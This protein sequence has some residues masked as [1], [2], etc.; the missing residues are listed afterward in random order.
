MP[1]N[2]LEVLSIKNRW[3][4]INAGLYKASNPGK[5][6][7]GFVYEW[8]IELLSSNPGTIPVAVFLLEKIKN[9][10]LAVSH[11]IIE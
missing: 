2:V 4:R 5:S 7:S 10:T 6:L 1:S 8:L 3:L 9:E 11:E